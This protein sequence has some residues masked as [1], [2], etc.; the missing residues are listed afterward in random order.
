MSG[1]KVLIVEDEMVVATDIQQRLE[2]MGYTVPAIAS[3][4]KEAIRLVEEHR[5]D[6][7]LMDIV[8]RGKM[9][10]IE[11]AMEIAGHYNVPVVYLSAYTDE[12]TLQRAKA[13]GFFGYLVKP[14]DDPQLQV[15]IEM[16][17][18]KHASDMALKESEE[19]FRRLAEATSEGILV[20]E[21]GL[22]LDLNNRMAQMLGY[23][24]REL[25]GRDIFE[26][27]MPGYREAASRN[28][29]PGLEDILEVEMKRK[30]GST[31][32]AELTVHSIP[33]QSRT[34]K[35]AAIRDITVRKH[36]ENLMKERARSE[37]YGFVVSALPLIAPGPHQEV[38]ADL[39][40]IFAERFE[41]FFKP[42]FNAHMKRHGFGEAPAGEEA[43]EDYLAWAAELFTGFGIDVVMSAKDGRGLLEFHSCPWIDYARQNPV[44]C[45]LCRAMASRSFSWVSPRG[46]TGL[47]STMAGGR[48]SCRFEFKP[49]PAGR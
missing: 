1:K 9:D 40:K 26:L 21:D 31:F 48:D 46:A 32:P 42:G 15:N 49:S 37:L 27:A 2:C 25:M 10:G 12:E 30:D 41:E 7:V 33:Y 44:F 14:I 39:L 11:A 22:A 23:E 47:N 29:W 5:P 28:E 18:Y 38:R 17:L 24:P 34:V 43:M 4:G 36:V 6:M 20:H 8:L 16:A 3:S 19:R 13:S 35:V 45:H